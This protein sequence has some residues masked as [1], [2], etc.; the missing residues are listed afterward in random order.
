[1]NWIKIE[2]PYCRRRIPLNSVNCPNCR[3]VIPHECGEAERKK[4]MLVI[5]ILFSIVIIGVGA[6]A[7]YYTF[8]LL[9]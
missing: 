2:C 3:S 7:L 4:F 6:T 9:A 1:M 5:L 8:H